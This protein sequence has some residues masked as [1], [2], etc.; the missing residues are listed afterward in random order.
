VIKEPSNASDQGIEEVKATYRRMA[1]ID[2]PALRSLAREL[3]RASDR[4]LAAATLQAR[5]AA[6]ARA[7]R[8]TER[9][10][11][12]HEALDSVETQG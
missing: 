9:A 8:D 10:A 6:Q 11:A 7:R 1:T 4:S 3:K 2:L 12:T 5:P